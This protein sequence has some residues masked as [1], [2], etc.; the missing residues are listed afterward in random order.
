M[1]LP[2]DAP[3]MVAAREL[4]TSAA[5]PH[6]EWPGLADVVD[7]ETCALDR[8]ELIE[9]I[10]VLAAAIEKIARPVDDVLDRIAD[11]ETRRGVE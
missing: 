8:K 6:R 11:P 7:L 3:S 5:R 1:H 10:A 2:V 4:I 9:V